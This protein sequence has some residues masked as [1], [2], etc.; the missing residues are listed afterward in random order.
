MTYYMKC[1]K[2]IRRKEPSSGSVGNDSGMYVAY[3]H[4]YLSLP[5]ILSYLS[6]SMRI[7]IRNL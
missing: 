1:G 4:D 6:S 3:C 7:A 5:P 2:N